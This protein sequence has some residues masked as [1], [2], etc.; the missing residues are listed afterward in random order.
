M[1][2]PELMAPSDHELRHFRS[3]AVIGVSEDVGD[4]G[5]LSCPVPCVR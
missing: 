3:V 5:D 1:S 4:A 2:T